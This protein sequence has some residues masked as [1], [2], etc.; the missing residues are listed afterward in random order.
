MYYANA[1]AGK[2]ESPANTK[3]E[4]YDNPEADSNYGLFPDT[5]MRYSICPSSLLSEDP[6]AAE[7]KVRVLGG[8]S[9]LNM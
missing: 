1:L 2:M 9:W 7:L 8:C 6:L 4:D 5:E 3:D